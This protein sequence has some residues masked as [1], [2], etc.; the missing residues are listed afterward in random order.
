MKEILERIA[1]LIDV[2][3]ISTLILTIT[4]SIMALRHEITPQE[5]ITIFAVVISFYYGT[6]SI[7]NTDK[8]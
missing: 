1:K 2:K 5:Y 6:Q 3:S 8:K 4:F 7:K